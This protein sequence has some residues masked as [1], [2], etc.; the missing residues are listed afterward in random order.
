MKFTLDKKKFIEGLTLASK[1]VSSKQNAQILTGIYVNASD[2]M[3]ELQ[4]T[5]YEIGFII[6]IE[7]EVDEP[8]EIVLSGKYLVDAVRKLPGSEVSFNYNEVEKIA[9]ISSNKSKYRLL[10]MDSAEFPKVE[11]LEGGTSFTIKDEELFSIIRKT[12]FAA[13]TDELRPV[14]MGCFLQIEANKLEMAATN[15]FRIAINKLD[16]DSGSSVRLIIPAKALNELSHAYKEDEPQDIT[17]NQAKNQLGFE[18][19]NIYMTT[20]LIEGEY[21][22]YKRIVPQSAMTT[23]MVDKNALASA[24]DRVSLISNPKGIQ[25][26]HFEIKE[27][28]IHIDSNN[29]EIGKAEEEIEAEVEGEELSISFNAV[30]IMDATKVMKGDKIKISLNK[31]L[32]PVKIEDTEDTNFIYVVTPVRSQQ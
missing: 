1:A 10:S 17:V 26:V 21:P 29:P 19:G 3:I 7:A 23:V 20:R 2:K 28:L 14:F 6:K 22:D 27:G 16:V 24:V 9:H 30:Y 11:K 32:D 5:D 12:A 18:F 25:S 13:S 15:S 4:A 31:A 8:G